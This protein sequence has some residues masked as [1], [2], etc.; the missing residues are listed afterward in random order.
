MSCKQ[1]K[2][3]V[4]FATL[5]I[6]KCL[7]D[8][9]QCESRLKWGLFAPGNC[10][11]WYPGQLIQQVSFRLN[12][13]STC[14]TI[15][16]RVSMSPLMSSNLCNLIVLVFSMSDVLCL[17]ASL[18]S[19]RLCQLFC[20][21]Y[22]LFYFDSIVSLMSFSCFLPPVSCVSLSLSASLCPSVL[23]LDFINITDCSTSASSNRSGACVWAFH[24][25]WQ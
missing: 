19:L 15:I 11:S 25:S 6:N 22:F 4:I 10:Q 5:K 9:S 17:P 12:N 14:A 1:Q 20:L 7:W 8:S 21:G 24:H 2:H 23:F 13:M 16:V 3:F 18:S